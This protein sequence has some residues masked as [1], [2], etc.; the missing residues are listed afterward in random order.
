MAQL[1][2]TYYNSENSLICQPLISVKE[3][4]SLFRV[5]PLMSMPQ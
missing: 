5:K 4:V 1:N 2:M 3:V